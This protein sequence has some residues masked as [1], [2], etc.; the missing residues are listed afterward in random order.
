MARKTAHQRKFS[1]AARRCRGDASCMSAALSGYGRP[2]RRK[3]KRKTRKKRR[4]GYGI[5]PDQETFG[6]HCARGAMKMMPSGV[7][8]CTRY[9]YDK[10]WEK[11]R[12]NKRKK[13]GRKRG[14]EY[15]RG[16]WADFYDDYGM[17]SAA[18]PTKGMTCK[19]WEP[20]FG[21]DGRCKVRCASFKGGRGAGGMSRAKAE[22]ECVLKPTKRS[23]KAKL[24]EKKKAEI[25]QRLK[26]ARK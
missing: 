10:E 22:T 13:K 3:K 7:R 25:K 6:T 8:R 1:K 12:A 14:S 11:Y 26:R 17:R 20:V 21:S 5:L 2:T 15:R 19:K 23:K 4:T 24:T 16:I 9:V 18:M